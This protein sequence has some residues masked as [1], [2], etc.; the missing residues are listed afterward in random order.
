MRVSAIPHFFK[1]CHKPVIHLSF[2]LNRQEP[3][4][5][6]C[7]IQKDALC[8]RSFVY[9]PFFLQVLKER[10]RTMVFPPTILTV[11]LVFVIKQRSGDLTPLLPF[12]TLIYKCFDRIC[13]PVQFFHPLLRTSALREFSIGIELL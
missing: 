13:F 8:C 4:I 7:Y 3:V 12:Q 6:Q 5:L 10:L 2:L 11:F 1:S 9:E